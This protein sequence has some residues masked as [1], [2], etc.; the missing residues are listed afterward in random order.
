MRTFYISDIHGHYIPLRKLLDS[1]NWNP[2]EDKLILGGDLINRGP[3]SAKVLQFAQTLQQQQPANVHVLCGNH[4][5][6]LIWYL[7][8]KSP[9]W[10]QHGGLETLYSLR[11]H[12]EDVWKAAEAYASWLESLAL[13]YEDNSAIYTHS[14]INPSFPKR[15]QP[16][17]IL[18]MNIREVLSQNPQKLLTWSDEKPIFRGHSPVRTVHTKGAYTHCDLGMGV[19][20]SSQ[21]AL[22]LVNVTEGIYYRCTTDGIITVHFI[23]SFT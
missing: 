7:R 11:Q 8:N 3:D 5:E 16:R 6:M 23:E 19:I 4:E 14:G 10:L 18:W 9:M 21:A 2:E 12:F 20:P 15:Q 1:V 13:V 22:A 17:E